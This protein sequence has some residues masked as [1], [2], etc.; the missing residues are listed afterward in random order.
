MEFLES[1]VVN[2]MGIE[3]AVLFII[4]SLAIG[5]GENNPKEITAKRSRKYST[6]I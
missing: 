3:M 2:R 4:W 1:Q 6:C 5:M